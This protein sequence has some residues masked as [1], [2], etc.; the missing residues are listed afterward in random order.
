MSIPLVVYEDMNPHI[1]AHIEASIPLFSGPDT[2]T[3]TNSNTY[4]R[5][6]MLTALVC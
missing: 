2:I 3:L 4:Y 1:Q 6:L 5:Q